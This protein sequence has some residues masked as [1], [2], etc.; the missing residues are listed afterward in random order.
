MNR[1]CISERLEAEAAL[2]K[3]EV[4]KSEPRAT[5]LLIIG[6]TAWVVLNS[7]SEIHRRIWKDLPPAPEGL[8]PPEDQE[9][10]G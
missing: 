10:N 7:R 3:Y 5:D 4:G 9:N 1:T 6:V 2:S 8:F